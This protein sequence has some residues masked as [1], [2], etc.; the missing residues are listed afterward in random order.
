MA[1]HQEPLADAIARADKSIRFTADNGEE[2]GPYDAAPFAIERDGVMHEG[3]RMA[4]EGQT[5]SVFFAIQP[6]EGDAVWC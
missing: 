4:V 5:I 6:Q 3:E 1:L 2:N